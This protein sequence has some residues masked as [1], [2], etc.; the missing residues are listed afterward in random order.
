MA[1]S[2]TLLLL[3]MSR[4]L[5]LST[6]LLAQAE[7]PGLSLGDVRRVLWFVVRFTVVAEVL[8]A[9]VLST[10]LLLRYDESIGR[11][12]WYG[13]FHTVSA[14]NNAGFALYPDSL[15]GFADDPFV[16]VPI[17][18]AI[19]VGGLGFIVF[20]DVFERLEDQ[21]GQRRWKRPGEWSLHSRLTIVGTVVLLV[22]G[23][24][25]FTLFERSNPGTMAGSPTGQH[26]LDG[27]FGSVT[28]RTAGFNTLDYGAA[29]EETLVTT[30][31][32]MI[33]GGGSASTAGGIKVS[34]LLILLLVIR[35]EARGDRD[36]QAFGR[37]VGAKT[38]R[39]AIAVAGSYFFLVSV[40]LLAIMT[41]SNVPLRDG[42]FETV[43]AIA[44]VGL[45]TGITADLPA[46]A[47]LVLVALMFT[48]RIGAMTL[49]TAF[50]LRRRGEPQRFRYPEGT[51][52][53]G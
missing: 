20:R 36:V 45:S 38:V 33:I 26:V 21:Y 50:S 30:S 19:V 22:L 14:F 15:I 51:P 9:L 46:P 35:A 11:A 39:T 12:V 25:L 7:T 42:L 13:V 52:I 18:V 2:G 24:V 16:L 47:L 17:M 6:R 1:T 8:L 44:T 43:S 53:I 29:R 48:G 10:V 3:V 32:L 41:L 31:L 28:A 23:A 34:T 4:R 37:R 40:G 49:A 5:G 27:V